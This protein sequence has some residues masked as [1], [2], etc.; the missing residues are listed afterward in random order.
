MRTFEHRRI[1]IKYLPTSHKMDELL[2]AY[3]S[4]EGEPKNN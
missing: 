3:K 1:R 4:S 2:V